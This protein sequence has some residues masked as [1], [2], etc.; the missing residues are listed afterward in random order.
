MCSAF[1]WSGSPHDTTKA[2]IA[3]EEVCPLVEGGL[4]IRRVREVCNVFMLKLIWRFFSCSSSLWGGWAKH[5]LLRGE[6]FWDVK[7]TGLGSWVWRKLLKLKPLAKHF[8]RMDIH[9]GRSVRFWT[10]LCHPQGR[11]IEITGEIGTQKLGISREARI[12][13]VFRDGV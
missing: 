3:W 10:D 9:D 6:S 1:L 11:L 5:Y 13:D 12:C 7:D 2:K 8:I 4:G